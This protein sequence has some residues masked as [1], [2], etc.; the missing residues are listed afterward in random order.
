[1]AV[2]AALAAGL[3]DVSHIHGG[4]DAW[5]NAGGELAAAG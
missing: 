3:S 5:K 1:M 2:D 4:I